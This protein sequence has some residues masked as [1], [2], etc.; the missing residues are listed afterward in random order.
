MLQVVQAVV[1]ARGEETRLERARRL[2]VRPFSTEN[3]PAG[4]GARYWTAERVGQL[5]AQNDA[6][7]EKRGKR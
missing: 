4:Q 7:R 6:L 2:Y 5:A 3:W 1:A